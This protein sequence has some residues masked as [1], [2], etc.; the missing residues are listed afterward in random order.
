[1]TGAAS[2]IRYTAAALAPATDASSAKAAPS[3][4]ARP[5]RIRW[6][7]PSPNPVSAF[8]VAAGFV[9]LESL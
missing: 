7:L 5:P 1:M 3:S 6:T 4:F 9:A 2:P 8:I